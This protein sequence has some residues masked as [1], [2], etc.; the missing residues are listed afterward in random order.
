MTTAWKSSA[1][2]E[3]SQ[4]PGTLIL[5]LRGELDAASRELIEAA[6]MAAIPSAYAVIL[7]LRDLTFCDSSGVSMFVALAGKARAAGTTLTICNPRT[8]IA[9][10]FSITGIDTLL[11]ITA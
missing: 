8:A 2:V 11:E 4:E 3:V 5:H 6:A 9:R 10:L 1:S 7:D